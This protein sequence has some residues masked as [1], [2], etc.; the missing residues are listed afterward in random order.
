MYL[1]SVGAFIAITTSLFAAGYTSEHQWIQIKQSIVLICIMIIII[2]SGIAHW[3]NVRWRNEITLWSDVVEKNR[4]NERAHNNLGLAYQVKGLHDA[5]IEQFQIALSLKPDDA[6]AYNNLGNT[7]Q[8]KGLTDRAI[9]Q[10][11]KP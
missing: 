7:Y 5:A 2:L 4:N 8:S 6:E 3:K 9:Q 11:Q 10:Y 1:P